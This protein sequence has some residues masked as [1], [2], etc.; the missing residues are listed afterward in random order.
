MNGLWLQ[1]SLEPPETSLRVL[2]LKGI[3][4]LIDTAGIRE[5]ADVVE[6]LEWSGQ[7]SFGVRQI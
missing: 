7:F 6:R 1:I 5:S 2:N 3:L 4:R